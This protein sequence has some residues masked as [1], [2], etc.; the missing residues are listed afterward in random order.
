[1]WQSGDWLNSAASYTG[2]EYDNP[3][4]ATHTVAATLTQSETADRDHT[5]PVGA[6][7]TEASF[8]E[9]A[10]WSESGV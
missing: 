6:E 9:T 10:A 2:L 1:M 7:P 4:D 5:A 8:W 3:K